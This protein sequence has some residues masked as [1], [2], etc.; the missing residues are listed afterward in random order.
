MW[1]HAAMRD[2]LGTLIRRGVSVI[3]PTEGPMACGEFGEGRLAEPDQITGAILRRLGLE[4]SSTLSKQPMERKASSLSGRRILVT[5]GPTHEPIDSVRYIANRSSGKQGHA[6]AEALT[7][8]GADVTLVS[9]PTDLPKPPGV[10]IRRV[11]TADQ[12]LAECTQALPVDCAIC[13][14]AVADWKVVQRASGKIKKQEGS[15]PP[16]LELCE[17]P[18]ILKTL[19][20]AGE[21]RPPL[22]IGFAA[23]T[24]DVVQRAVDKRARKGCDWILANDVSE[25]TGTFGGA[26]NTVHFITAEASDAWPTASKRAVADRLAQRIAHYF[27]T[28]PATPTDD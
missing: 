14:A 3:G 12:M 9:G 21:W 5:S 28:E 2:N 27:D 16:S 1:E 20:T 8:L 18:D 24:D 15:A 19:S 10:T 26:D 23:E 11:E 6:I 17:N 7:N 22:V 4:Y 25:G 13:A